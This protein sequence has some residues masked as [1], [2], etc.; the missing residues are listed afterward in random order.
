M[1]SQKVFAAEELRP[2][3]W[4][5]AWYAGSLVTASVIYFCYKDPSA[6]QQGSVGIRNLSRHNVLFMFY[7]A[8]ITVLCLMLG[9]VVLRTTPQNLSQPI[10][11]I[12]EAVGGI[13]IGV[14]FFGEGRH[15]TK[16]ERIAMK[17]GL[18]GIV[19]IGLATYF[20]I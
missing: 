14:R 7:L 1:F 15:F 8:S 6:N 11:M 18:F 9:H 19:L 2:G 13:W 4:G 5:L 3:H 10:M 20:K 12:G 16:G 17:V